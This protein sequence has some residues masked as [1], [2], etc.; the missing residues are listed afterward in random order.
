MPEACK[1]RILTGFWHFTI[2]IPGEKGQATLLYI[3]NRLPFTLHIFQLYAVRTI[4]TAGY[5][6][7]QN[8]CSKTL[9]VEITILYTQLYKQQNPCREIQNRF[10]EE[11]LQKYEPDL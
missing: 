9:A 11:L 2:Q 6:I 5:L 3:T 1:R 10:P 8:K 7:A 4:D